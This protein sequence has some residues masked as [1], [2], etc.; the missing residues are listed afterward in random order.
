[1]PISGCK[2]VQQTG[3]RTY[4]QMRYVT[5]PPF[6]ASSGWLCMVFHMNEHFAYNEE[7]WGPRCL[8]N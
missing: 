8:D 6:T 3:I 7:G 4:T 5:A 2:A 1:M